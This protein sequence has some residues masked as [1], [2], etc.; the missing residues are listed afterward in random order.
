M[1]PEKEISTIDR[2]HIAAKTEFLEKGF[3]SA[4]LRNI[5]KTAGVTTGAFYGYY[6]SKEELF[7]ALVSEVYNHIIG[8]YTD[9]LNNFQELPPEK[10]VEEMGQISK[11]CLY[12]ILDYSLEH[13]AE[14]HLIIQC[15]DGTPYAFLIDNMIELEID[16]TRKYYKTL[17]SLGFGVP[18]IEKMSEHILV[19]GMINSFFEI[20][21][22]EL[23]AAEA[24]VCLT[25][26]FDFYKAGWEKI[27]G[28]S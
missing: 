19:T 4:S 20:I 5:V 9:S 22:H 8:E 24:R 6:T 21:I 14:L 11:H 26:L 25:Q 13:I 10:Q 16:G 2:I 17:E 15:S 18:K 12:S 1:T 27:M 3:K 23:P 7:K 28:Q